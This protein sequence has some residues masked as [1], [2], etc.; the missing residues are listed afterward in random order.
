MEKIKR[1]QNEMNQELEFYEKQSM[2]KDEEINRHRFKLESYMKNVE[3]ER[4]TYMS[5]ILSLVSIGTTAGYQLAAVQGSIAAAMSS[6]A[7]TT[8]IFGTTGALTAGAAAAS[9]AATS[10]AAASASATMF[11]TGA[12]M[13]V[14]AETA[15]VSTA[16]SC[17][18]S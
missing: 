10:S 3:E 13:G 12:A 15:V 6:T 5:S 14:A 4:T 18:I 17:V 9:L 8:A 2:L 16:L 11:G 1:Q 7:A